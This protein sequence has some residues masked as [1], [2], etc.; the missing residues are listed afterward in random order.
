MYG[1]EDSFRH[2][3]QPQKIQHRR[4]SSKNNSKCNKA[5]GIY[6][7]YKVLISAC[8]YAVC[9]RCDRAKEIGVDQPSFEDS[10]INLVIFQR[11]LS[12]IMNKHIPL[13]N[14]IKE[15]GPLIEKFTCLLNAFSKL[16][17][18]L[19]AYV[20]LKAI[21]L[22]HYGNPISDDEK[23]T[24]L[25]AIYSPKVQIIQDQF[26]K[27]LQIHL[28]QFENGPRLSDLLGFLPNLNSTATVL[29]NSKMFYV[30]FLIC[31][32]PDRFEHNPDENDYDQPDAQ[33]EA[34][35]TSSSISDVDATDLS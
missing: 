12:T 1:A 18:T 20:C 21:A 13:E 17:I 3:C 33:S 19:E 5:K 25:H 29:L 30:P 35:C 16:K 23:I 11:R 24:N 9:T 22:V 32:E 4:H 8:F 28:S 15:A 27:A 26:V 6:A 2:P 10:Q 31:R 7:H 34:N 14:V